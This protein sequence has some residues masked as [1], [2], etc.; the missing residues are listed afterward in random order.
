[1][2]S[3]DSLKASDIL[4]SPE[5]GDFSTGDFDALPKIVPLGE[6]A[7][8][9]VVERLNALAIPPAEYAALR[10]GQSVEVAP[11][12]R[13]VD[14]IRIAP[15]ER[16]NPEI[17]E[18]V[19]KTTS[20]KPIDQQELDRD[21]A[22]IYGLGNFETVNYSFLEEPGRRI[23]VVNAVEK[24]RGL[25]SIRLGLGLSSDFQS[26]SY[27]NVIG[28][29]RQYWLNS[30]GAEWRT[31]VQIGRSSSL[32]SEFYQPLTAAGRLFVAPSVNY[33]RRTTEI[34]GS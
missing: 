15:M 24:I 27:F 7:A 13:A 3:I 2:S 17:I 19:M 31:D 18:A 5:L 33:E 16:V 21:M 10:K 12:L 20:G 30:F 1:M 34:Y 4:I 8:R 23:L 25:K 26:A 29:Y 6:S 11:D 28:S 9:K 22:R 32:R 14:E